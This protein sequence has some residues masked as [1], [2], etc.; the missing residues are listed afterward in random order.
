MPIMRPTRNDTNDEIS[1]LCTIERT[2]QKGCEALVGRMDGGGEPRVP[3][4]A[5]VPLKNNP[6]APQTKRRHRSEVVY[7]YPFEKKDEYEPC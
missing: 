6:G 3:F 7:V 4:Q 2:G 5:R 1:I